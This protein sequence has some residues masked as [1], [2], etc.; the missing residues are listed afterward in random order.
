MNIKTVLNRLKL[1]GATRNLKASTAYNRLIA[2]VE[3]GLF[4]LVQVLQNNI[5][6]S[7]ALSFAFGKDLT[8]NPKAS[9]SH[10]I[11]FSKALTDTINATDDV[12]GVADPDDQ[13]N[14][15]FNQSSADSTGFS[16]VQ[17]FAVGK[18]L[19]DSSNTSDSAVLTANKSLSDTQAATD[20]DAKAFSKALGLD[21][22][23]DYVTDG[24]F[25]D[26]YVVGSSTEILAA[27]ET[28][29][30]GFTT[31][32]ADSSVSTDE[33]DRQVDY[34]RSLSDTVYATDDIYNQQGVD[35]QQNI[36]FYKNTL[37]LPLVSEVFSLQLGRVLSDTA[38]S[39]DATAV[40]FTRPLSDSY[41]ATDAEY[42][43][44]GKNFTETKSFTD[45]NV[46]DFNKYASDGTQTT[47][48][49]I[50]SVQ[51]TRSDSASSSDSG[52]L[53][54]QGY[55]NTTDYFADDFVGA[56]RAI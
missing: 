6:L 52:T 45:A 8:D 16:D 47:D 3:K 10:S 26:D 23:Q 20:S 53:L 46:I 50:K 42:H 39:S 15:D 55:T 51:Q 38:S 27:A 28:F 21:T 18:A 41:G 37:E 5:S 35:D 14:M 44:V 19:S 31:G 9:E 43:N 12:Y 17:T 36:Q 32:F 22:D 24:Y 30:L 40:A 48:Q 56:K 25:W 49:T 33:F 54:N 4:L 34:S 2:K 11:A 29:S 1:S 13:Q 7:E